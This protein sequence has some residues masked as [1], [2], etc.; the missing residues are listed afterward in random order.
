MDTESFLSPLS[1][2]DTVN[3]APNWNFWVNFNLSFNVFIEFLCLSS[4]LLLFIVAPT[5]EV[6]ALFV[7]VIHLHDQTML[8]FR[9]L[10]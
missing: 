6:Q 8:P 7:T 3:L 4:S 5:S 10:Q 9:G 1:I 2:S